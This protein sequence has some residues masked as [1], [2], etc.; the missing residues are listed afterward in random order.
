RSAKQAH[1]LTLYNLVGRLLIDADRMD[2]AATVSETG[3]RLMEEHGIVWGQAECHCLLAERLLHTGQW[4]DAVA[5]SET[6]VDLCTTFDAW[7]AFGMAK[8]ILALVAVRRNELRRA[9]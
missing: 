3:R 2:E 6:T 4:D 1:V 7:H 9:E 5:E 8:S